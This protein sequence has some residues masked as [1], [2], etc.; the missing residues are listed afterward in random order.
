MCRMWLLIDCPRDICVENVMIIIYPRD[1]CVDI[2]VILT[3]VNFMDIGLSI[4]LE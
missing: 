3:L 1:I 2:V 4:H